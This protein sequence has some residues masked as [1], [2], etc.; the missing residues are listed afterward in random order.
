MY[1][2]EVASQLL[3]FIIVVITDAGERHE[4]DG[5]YLTSIDAQV[6]AMRRFPGARRIEVKPHPAG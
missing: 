2:F 3:P 1:D 5:L 6:D 4:F